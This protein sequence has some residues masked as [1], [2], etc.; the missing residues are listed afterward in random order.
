MM[1]EKEKRKKDTGFKNSFINICS[2][3][4]SNK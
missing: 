2:K 1:P 3:L 4:V